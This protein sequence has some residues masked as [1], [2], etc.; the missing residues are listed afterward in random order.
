MLSFE[1]CYWTSLIDIELIAWFF[2]N[3]SLTSMV[4]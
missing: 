3:A 1:M 2:E 4:D